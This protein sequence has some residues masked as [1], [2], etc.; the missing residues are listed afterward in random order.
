MQTNVK[1]KVLPK[2]SFKAQTLALFAALA[3]AVALPQ[4]FHLV[5]AVS[6]LGTTI[7]ASFL[8]MHLPIMI[9]GFIAGPYAGLVAG[10][11]APVV[12][13]FL[14]GMPTLA[15]LPLMIAEISTYGLFAGLLRNAKIS[16]FGKL[17]S[18]Q[19]LGRAA[20]AVVTVAVV[21]FVSGTPITLSSIYT[22]ILTGLPGIIIQWAVLPLLLY[23]VNNRFGEEV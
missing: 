9:V 15:M 5:G 3:S 21:L 11:L 6:N 14:S 4:I 7:G 13:F 2:L 1:T 19:L 22:S 17:L 16:A 18:V 10:A 20:R 12:S 23:F 8:P